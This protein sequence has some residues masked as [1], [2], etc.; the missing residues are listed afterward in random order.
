M[1][2][3]RV[4]PINH[5]AT[6]RD[7]QKVG[8]TAR[9]STFDAPVDRGERPKM[10]GG[11]P[12]VDCRNRRHPM[13]VLVLIGNSPGNSMSNRGDLRAFV[14]R[15]VPGLCFAK[16]DQ[17]RVDVEGIALVAAFGRDNRCRARS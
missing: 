7:L 9:L 5:D 3:C 10:S 4:R 6:K 8:D 1:V 11:P 15:V 2:E 12:S 16:P 17:E 14:F 13:V